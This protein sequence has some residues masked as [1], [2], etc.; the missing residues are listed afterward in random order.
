MKNAR[1]EKI[2]A[3]ILNNTVETQEE[4]QNYLKE[5]GFNVTQATISRDI[6][7]LRLIKSQSPGGT[8]RYICPLPKMEALGIEYSNIFAHS[9][10]SVD[11]A[12]NNVVVKCR[13]GMAQAACA[14]LDDM[15]WDIIVG[16]LAGEDTIF[17]IVRTEQQAETLV[18]EL[19]NLV[20]AR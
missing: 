7:E 4:L 18:H 15:N 3:I 12:M 8:Y 17:I 6:K 20:S 14:A 19:N 5:A 10:L 9:V 13:S 16:T 11:Y 1:H 2:K